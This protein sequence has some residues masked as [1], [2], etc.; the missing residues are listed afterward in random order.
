M[1]SLCP[2]CLEDE[3]TNGHLFCCQNEASIAQRKQEIHPI[4]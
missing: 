4:L 3:E 2:R 1:S